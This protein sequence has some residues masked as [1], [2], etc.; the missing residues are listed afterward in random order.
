[1]Y[2]VEPCKSKNI[3]VTVS[4]DP[5]S[6][7]TVSSRMP[8][9]AHPPIDVPDV[10]RLVHPAQ[11]VLDLPDQDVTAAALGALQVRT[12]AS[13]TSASGSPRARRTCATSRWRARTLGPVAGPLELAPARPSGR[14]SASSYRPRAAQQIS[15]GTTDVG[16]SVLEVR[17]SKQLAQPGRAAPPP[18][19]VPGRQR[20]QRP[21]LAGVRLGHRPVPLAAADALVEEF[22]GLG[23]PPGREGHLPQMVVHLGGGAVLTEAADDVQVV[24]EVLLRLGQVAPVQGEAA[25]L[26]VG[27]GQARLVA[28][29]RLQ[30]AARP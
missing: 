16:Q 21:V 27:E 5:G 18:R 10:G 2:S 26:P 19:R 20:R 4:R 29:L 22:D 17:F 14:A 28:A 23:H 8:R 24:P 3:T 30:A 7:A 25:E 15:A 11:L 9:P 6:S 1:M 12:R 13:A